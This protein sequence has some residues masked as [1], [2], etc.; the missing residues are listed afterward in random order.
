MDNTYYL[1]EACDHSKGERLDEA[2][3][4]SWLRKQ[5]R[6]TNRVAKWNQGEAR[7]HEARMKTWADRMVRENPS[8]SF[9]ASLKRTEEGAAARAQ[10]TLLGVSEQQASVLMEYRRRSGSSI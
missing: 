3:T 4:Y 8:E 6:F 1:D 10:L 7:R 5:S 9:R 2:D